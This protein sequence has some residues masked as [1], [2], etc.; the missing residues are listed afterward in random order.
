MSQQ[1]MEIT[2]WPLGLEPLSVRLRLMDH[3]RLARSSAFLSTCT[4]SVTTDSS[5]DLDT[6]S[7]GS[8]FPEK[9]NSL[10]KL[11]GIGSAKPSK[12]SR[13]ATPHFL[14][15]D[16]NRRRKSFRQWSLC[17]AMG[18]A[19]SNI[20]DPSSSPSLSHLLE[21]ERRI[22]TI[23]AGI[24][25]AVEH[26]M[27]EERSIRRNS[28]CTNNQV[29]SQASG[30]SFQLVLQP[31]NPTASYLSGDWETVPI[32]GNQLNRGKAS[33]HPRRYSQDTQGSTCWSCICNSRSNTSAASASC[34]QN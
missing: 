10:G 7:T 16:V 9:N 4:P 11:I 27:E 3:F 1:D 32:P 2:G 21:L 26:A 22:P 13:T 19:D 6:E 31:G 33:H 23:E 15:N 29:L 24:T 18:C 28:L 17:S 5:S 14:A 34:S 30:A 8:F 25:L 20:S 12:N